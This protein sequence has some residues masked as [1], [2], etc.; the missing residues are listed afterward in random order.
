MFILF[1]VDPKQAAIYMAAKR[2]QPN[3]E[4]D[5]VLYGNVLSP[6]D[7]FATTPESAYGGLQFQASS[8]YDV[9]EAF[10]GFGGCHLPDT[11]GFTL[12]W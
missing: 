6:H 1:I 9:N 4:P 5:E 8:P 3:Y 2:N 11:Q 10:Q 12:C 7:G